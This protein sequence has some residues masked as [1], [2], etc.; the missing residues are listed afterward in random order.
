MK[1]QIIMSSKEIDR[2]TVLEKLIRKEIKQKTAA[3]VLGLSTR[4]VRRI[5][6][7]YKRLGA[8]SLVHANRGKVPNNKVADKEIERVTKIIKDQYSD[9]GPTLAHEKLV[10]NHVVTFSV[11]RLRQ[12]MIGG[13]IWQAKKKKHTRVFQLRERRACEGELVQVDGSPHDWFEGRAGYC[14]LLVYIDDATG[15]L[16]HLEFAKSENTLS[17][18]KATKTYLGNHG[19]PLAFYVDKHSVFR[20]NTSKGGSS[21]LV[22]N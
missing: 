5:K 6:Q 3:R 22:L 10:E 12:I 4:Q 20:I 11:E 21:C 17:Y 14:T 18:F 7:K 2:V 9:F 13:N 16:L 19:K 15:K 1:G 8:S